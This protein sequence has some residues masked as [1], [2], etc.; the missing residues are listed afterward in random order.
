ME[1]SLTKLTIPQLESFLME[2]IS[3][4]E[5][6]GNEWAAKKS[7]YESIDDKKKPMI[8][9][10]MDK[11]EGS[12]PTKESKALSHPEYMKFLNGLSAARENYYLTQVGY[13]MAKLKVDAIRTVISARKEEIKRFKA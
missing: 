8:A 4:A 11:F 7:L 9:T 12:N 10:L 2:W 5:E 3:E 13:D 6:K 1:S